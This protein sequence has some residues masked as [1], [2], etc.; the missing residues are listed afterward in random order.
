MAP[1]TGDTTPL[2]ILDKFRYPPPSVILSYILLELGDK[3]LLFDLNPKAPIPL[4]LP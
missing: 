2:L 3:T 4:P 1:L